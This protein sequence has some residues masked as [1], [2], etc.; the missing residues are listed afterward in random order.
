MSALTLR[1]LGLYH[2]HFDIVTLSVQDYKDGRLAKTSSVQVRAQNNEDKD[3]WVG[4]KIDSSQEVLGLSVNGVS[5]VSSKTKLVASAAN[6]FNQLMPPRPGEK[7]VAYKIGQP[8]LPRAFTV[9]TELKLN[10]HVAMFPDA[11]TVVV[12]LCY[13]ADAGVA[14]DRKNVLIGH[15]LIQSPPPETKGSRKA[16]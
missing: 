11:Q 1:G 8:K 6:Q 16:K 9:E 3:L 10:K 15:S 2:D 7:W 14:L 12:V 4:L 5:W 13:A